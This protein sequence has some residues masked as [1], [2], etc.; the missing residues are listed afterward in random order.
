M[1]PRKTSTTTTNKAASTTKAKPRRTST[2]KE[3]VIVAESVS[4]PIVKQRKPIFS[5]GTWITVLLL[6]AVIGLSVYLTRQKEKTAAAEVTPASSPEAIF[7]AQDGTVSSI[8]IKP[9]TGEIVKVTRNAENVWAVE[10]PIQAEANQGLA[11]AAATQVS[12]LQV[13][14]PIENA[15]PDIFGL[16]NPTYTIT[17]GF[18]N[19]QTRTLEI[20][21]ATPSNN[22]YYVRVDKDKMMITDLSGIDAL[23]QLAQFPPYLNTPTPTALPATP[24][25]VPPTPVLPTAA[26]STPTP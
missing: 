2:P 9:A 24:T 12:A 4:T 17:V 7:S 26:V 20:G 25:P 23:L 11:E 19:G 15:D 10:M 5:A 13:L 18:N 3:K 1:A 14:R 21:D 16:K 22:G 8:E 6:I